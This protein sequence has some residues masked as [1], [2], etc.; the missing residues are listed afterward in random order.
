MPAACIIV[1]ENYRIRK[2]LHSKTGNTEMHK[3]GGCV[4]NVNIGN[5]IFRLTVYLQLFNLI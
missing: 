2:A 1:T 5:I 4:A 3:K